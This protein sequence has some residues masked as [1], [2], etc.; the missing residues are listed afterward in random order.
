ME[1]G[2]CALCLDE[3]PL[4]SS[5]Y[6]GKALYALSR[7][8]GDSPI[9]M[10][11]NL[12]VQTDQQI[13]SVRLCWDCEQLFSLRGEEYAMSMVDREGEFKLL[14]LLRSATRCRPEGEY[15]AYFGSGLSVDCDSLAYFAL[16]VIW[17][18]GH[19][20]RSLSGR[21]TGG[22]Q[23]GRFQEPLRQYLLGKTPHPQGVVVKITVATDFA[24]GT[25]FCFREQVKVGE[26]PLSSI[27]W[28]AASGSISP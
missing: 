23:L 7:T 17:R 3:R 20:W 28:R 27:L 11:P 4:C 19:I 24:L 8:D 5:H 22:L 14:N 25:W 16:S 10:S 2:M 15:T 6:I 21:T 18:G 1:R 26:T 13:K 12:I 9:L